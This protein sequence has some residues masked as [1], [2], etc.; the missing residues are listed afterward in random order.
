[1]HVFFKVSGFPE[2]RKMP[3]VQENGEPWD[4]MRAG[5]LL[6]DEA[7]PQGGE[8]L[9]VASGS[10]LPSVPDPMTAIQVHLGW[11]LGEIQDM[12]DENRAMKD[13]NRALRESF[14]ALSARMDLLETQAAQPQV[15]QVP[16]Q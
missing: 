16:F 4:D 13:E 9:G 11:A 5:P 8:G 2:G 14:C 3:N 10:G 6:G 1:M 12:K 15:P 7:G